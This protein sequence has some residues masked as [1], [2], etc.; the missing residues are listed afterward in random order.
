MK[1]EV[2]ISENYTTNNCYEIFVECISEGDYMNSKY[3]CYSD[4]YREL[5]QIVGEQNMKK[6][7]AQFR[8]ISVQF[9][10]R[11]YS[12]EYIR[13]FIKDHMEIEKA[14][15]IARQVT[16]SERRVRQIIKEIKEGEKE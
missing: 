10:Q 12:K 6:I 9:P 8:G 3:E 14:S 11:L 1:K 15:E 16:L 2:K 7:Y 13:D 5:C 4:I